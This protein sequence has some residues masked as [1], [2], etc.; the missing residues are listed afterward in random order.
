MEFFSTS[1]WDEALWEN[2][3]VIYNEAFAAHGGKPEKII[4]NMFK[5]GLSFLHIALLEKEVLAIALTGRTNGSD[6]LIIDYL[7]VRRD[8][9]SQGIGEKLMEYIKDW[10]ISQRIYNS[11]LIEVECEQTSENL[12]RINFWEKCGFTLL[13]DYTHQYIWVPEPYQAMLLDFQKGK[14]ELPTGKEMFKTIV[15]FHKQSFKGTN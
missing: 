12:A 10:T 4:R 2:A 3:N 13:R 9:R 14:R 8:L 11:M 6:I 7:A 15:R 1:Q 5:K